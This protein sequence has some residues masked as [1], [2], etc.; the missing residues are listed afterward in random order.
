ML[1]KYQSSPYIGISPSSLR[2]PKLKA[3]IGFRNSIVVERSGEKPEMKN[4]GDESETDYYDSE[5]EYNNGEADEDKSELAIV[6][7]WQ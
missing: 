4:N 2:L 3:V 7:L 6:T 1:L 5:A